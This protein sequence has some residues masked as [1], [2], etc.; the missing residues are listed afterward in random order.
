[1][2][3]GEVSPSANI[4]C[5]SG[6]AILL[7]FFINFFKREL[8]GFAAVLLK[9]RGQVPWYVKQPR[10]VCRHSSMTVGERKLQKIVSANIVKAKETLGYIFIHVRR[11]WR[12]IWNNLNLRMWKMQRNLLWCLTGLVLKVMSC[13]KTG[14]FVT[15]S[16][17]VPILYLWQIVGKIWATLKWHAQ[18][19]N[20][21]TNN[22][23]IM[24]MQVLY[25]LAEGEF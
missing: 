4:F 19:F 22:D 24:K 1:M 9:P 7:F 11:F 21:N 6:F 15:K 2:G 12:N 25:N 3:R 17:K 5:H 18:F 14:E 10:C 8:Q 23:C 16:Q 20:I 13:S